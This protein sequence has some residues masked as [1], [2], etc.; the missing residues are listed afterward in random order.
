MKL[1]E[2]V[3][4]DES[5]G[6]YL[7]H[8]NHFKPG[9]KEVRF[10]AFMPPIDKNL[11]VYRIDGLKQSEIWVIGQENVISKNGHLYGLADI[12][13]LKVEKQK[14]KINPDNIPPRHAN[15][16]GWP[17]NPAE[18]MSIAYELAAEAT[19]VLME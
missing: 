19:L 12:K 3:N 18:Q 5:L 10:N 8:K 9:K 6:R 2:I 7:T 15:I 14:L 17:E 1:A 11:S 13:A 16:I 4:P